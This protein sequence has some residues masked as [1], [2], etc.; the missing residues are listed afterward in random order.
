MGVLANRPTSTLRYTLARSARLKPWK[1]M[2]MC[3]RRLRSRRPR[4][5]VTRCG[6]TVTVPLVAGT[7]PLIVRMSVDLPEPDNPTTET[8]S[9]AAMSRETLR[10]A[11]VPFG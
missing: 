9:P 8:I 11:L 6:P 10:S 7:R 5:P 4:R 3:P 2:P 1:I